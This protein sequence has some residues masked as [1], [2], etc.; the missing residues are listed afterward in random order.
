M[1]RSGVTKANEAVRRLLEVTSLPRS[2]GVTFTST[3]MVYGVTGTGVT[4]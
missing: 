4:D 3:E 1:A 2:A